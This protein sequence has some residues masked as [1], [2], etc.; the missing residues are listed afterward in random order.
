MEKKSNRRKGDPTSF[1]FN[2]GVRASATKLAEMDGL[3]VTDYLEQLI[4][5]DAKKKNFEILK[6]DKAANDE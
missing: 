2:P 1:R 3:T 5:K 4:R 6:S